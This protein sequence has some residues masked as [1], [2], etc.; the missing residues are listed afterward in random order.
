MHR[1]DTKYF[2]TKEE[3]QQWASTVKHGPASETYVRSNAYQSDAVWSD[4]QLPA[5]A[6]DYEIFY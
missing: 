6:V 2:R 5:W 4:T 3:A 1:N